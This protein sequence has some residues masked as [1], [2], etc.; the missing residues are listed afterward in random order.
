MSAHRNPN[1]ETSTN[2]LETEVG[3]HFSFIHRGHDLGQIVFSSQGE[4]HSAH[5]AENG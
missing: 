5:G 1:E 4:P 2:E 3:V